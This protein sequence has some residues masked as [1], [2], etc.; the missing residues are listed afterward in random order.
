MA[1]LLEER[2]ENA[3]AK[4]LADSL[5]E[6]AGAGELAESLRAEAKRRELS[7]MLLERNIDPD[8]TAD[9]KH[10]RYWI[11]ILAFTVLLGAVLYYFSPDRPLLPILSVL[12]PLML[13]WM[14]VRFWK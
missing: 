9:E 14:F 8:A 12:V 1:V 11:A 10:Y 6:H 3:G 2:G 4:A 13:I 7:A 5:A